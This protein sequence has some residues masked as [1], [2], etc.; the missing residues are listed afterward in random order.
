MQTYE[1]GHLQARN[2]T[3]AAAAR[4]ARLARVFAGRPSRDSADNSASA[5]SDAAAADLGLVNAAAARA[6]A[7]W[8]KEKA[9]VL[10]RLLAPPPP[11]SAPQRRLP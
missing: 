10:A 7:A 8:Q 6:E 1:Q 2:N 5:K 9:G 3:A 11:A 4:V